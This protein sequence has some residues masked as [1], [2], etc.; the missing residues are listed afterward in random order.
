MD[1]YY[2]N[3]RKL[4]EEELQEAFLRNASA[5]YSMLEMHPPS[6]PMQFN[7]AHVREAERVDA[8]VINPFTGETREVSNIVYEKRY[9]GLPPKRA[10]GVGRKLMEAI[11]GC[12]RICTIF[13]IRND[14]QIPFAITETK[15]VVKV[16]SWDKIRSLNHA[17]NPLNEI[18]AIEH[19]SQFPHENVMSA[20]DILQDE[21]YLLIFM[22]Y[23]S[24]GSLYDFVARAGHFPERVARYWFTQIIEVR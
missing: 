11:Y 3:V 4:S 9:D 17:E 5:S 13:E 14:V 15:A 12:I 10:Y 6:K 2:S 20:L 7:Q 8:Q 21:E 24:S 1:I 16:L 18:A 23:Y 19:V 22:P